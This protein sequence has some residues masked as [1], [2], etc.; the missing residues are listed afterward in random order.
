[1]ATRL[2][3]RQLYLESTQ[4]GGLKEGDEMRGGMGKISGGG[5]VNVNPVYDTLG[6]GSRSKTSL[7]EKMTY[8]RRE[9]KNM[10]VP[11][12]KGRILRL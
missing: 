7:Q 12:C 6:P 10:N 4:H 11:W 1:M 8:E 2:E 3:R 9:V 5:V